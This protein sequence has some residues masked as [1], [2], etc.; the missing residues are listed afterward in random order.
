MYIIGVLY[1]HAVV[2]QVVVCYCL[3]HI[4]RKKRYPPACH[5]KKTQR[6]RYVISSEK[7]EHCWTD[8]SR[9]EFPSCD[10]SS[11]QTALLFPSLINGHFYWIYSLIN[12]WTATDPS[13]PALRRI[14]GRSLH[15]QL[16]FSLFLSLVIV[17]LLEIRERDGYWEILRK[18][19]RHRNIDKSWMYVKT[20][21]ESISFLNEQQ[22]SR[23]YIWMNGLEQQ[24]LQPEQSCIIGH[25]SLTWGTGVQDY[26]VG[27][28]SSIKTKVSYS[29]YLLFMLTLRIQ[30][31]TLYSNSSNKIIIIVFSLSAS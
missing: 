7:S 26:K 9:S 30:Y 21:S 22:N 6:S 23:Y 15:S 2:S 8:K 31:T 18:P 24:G 11:G 19:D 3:L 25:L 5:C 12:K 13:K 10:I 20:I 28:E 4:I 27:T 17:I 29:F 1:V 16:S 14:L